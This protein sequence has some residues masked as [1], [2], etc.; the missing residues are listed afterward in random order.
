M[1]FEIKQNRTSLS[2]ILVLIDFDVRYYIEAS[3]F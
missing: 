2:I 1:T 3:V